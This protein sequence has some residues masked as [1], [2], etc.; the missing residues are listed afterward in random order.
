MA[1]FLYPFSKIIG[2]ELKYRGGYSFNKYNDDKV[3]NDIERH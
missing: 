3:S 1:A 2:I